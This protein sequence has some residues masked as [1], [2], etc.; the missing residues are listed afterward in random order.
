MKI[1]FLNVGHGDCTVIEHA[2]GRLT[3]VDVN[4]CTEL[5]HESLAEVSQYYRQGNM[6]LMLAEALGQR[7]YGMVKEA[8]YDIELTNPIE[9]LSK[10]YPGKDIF[11]YVQTHPHLDHLSGIEQ[12]KAHNIDIVN[13]WDTDHTFIPDLT[14]DADRKSWNE[15]KRL[16]GSPNGSPKVLRKYCGD[17]GTFWN[18]DPDGVDGG[19]GIDILHPNPATLRAIQDSDNVNDLSYVLRVT[20]G[21]VKIVLAGD[22]EEVVWDDLVKRY[23]S[24]LKCTVLKASH[25][26]RDSGYHDRAVELMK[27]QYTIVSVGKK[28]ETDA[29]DKYRKHSENVWSTR[30]KGNI[31]ITYDAAAKPTIRSQYDR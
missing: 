21:G 6:R 9:F 24:G 22:A 4:N 26:G 17:K 1:T 30:W 3:V 29:S 20:L 14:S 28:P 15:Y 16:R 23:G 11:R 13:F 25:H 18:Q 27:P 10:N 7:S 19:D 12:L 5:D 31:E 8:G 2:S